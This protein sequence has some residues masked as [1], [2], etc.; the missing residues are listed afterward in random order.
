MIF[1]KKDIY[2]P[3]SIL[4]SDKQNCE[5]ITTA[6]VQNDIII[7]YY[8]VNE[9]RQLT[10]KRLN[11]NIRAHTPKFRNEPRAESAA[12]HARRRISWSSDAEVDSAVEAVGAYDNSPRVH[13][14]RRHCYYEDVRFKF[15]P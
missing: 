10:Q 12:K 5:A 1:R 3:S 2:R 15:A 9:P 8:N 6:R 14:A 13:S 7:T 4:N 11:Y